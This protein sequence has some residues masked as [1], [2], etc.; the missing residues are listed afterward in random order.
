[1]LMK[2]KNKIMIKLVEFDSINK[3]IYYNMYMNT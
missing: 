2:K 3:I 1:M